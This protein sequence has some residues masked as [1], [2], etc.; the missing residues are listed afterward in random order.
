MALQISPQTIQTPSH[1]FARGFVGEPEFP[2]DFRQAHL[3]EVAQQNSLPLL[4]GK[5]VIE[6]SEL[7]GMNNTDVENIKRFLTTTTDEYVKKYEAIPTVHKRRC[8]FIGT[9]NERQPLKDTSGNRRFLPVNVPGEIDLDW[10]TSLLRK[11]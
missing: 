3:A 8:I 6:L 11:A 2:A 5:W 1:S 9:T 10:L 7:S 4:A